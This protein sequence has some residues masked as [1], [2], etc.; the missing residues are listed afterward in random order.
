[1]CPIEVKKSVKCFQVHGDGAHSE[2][3]TGGNTKTGCNCGNA[4]PF[5]ISAR[6]TIS[7]FDRSRN[8]KPDKRR[9]K[10]A[11]TG[12]PEPAVY[13]RSRLGPRTG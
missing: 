4:V 7:G 11:R 13:G 10:N 1:M 2:E 9:G 12:R 5:P 6:G 8:K 3:K